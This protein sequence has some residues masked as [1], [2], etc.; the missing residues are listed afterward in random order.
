MK[1]LFVSITLLGA[2][3]FSVSILGTAQSQT[4]FSGTWALDMKKTRDLP[5]D[6]KSYTLTV[7]QT[8][9][10]ISYESK[11]EGDLNAHHKQDQAGTGTETPIAAPLP[12]PNSSGA[13]G[14]GN[15]AVS[16]HSAQG[17]GSGKVMARGRAIGM[18]I[19]R[20]NCTL[21]GKEAAREVGGISPGQI[22]RRAQWRRGDK[23]LEF[24][25]AR[26][27]DVQGKTVTSTVKE[28]WELS[29]DGKVL[30]V[31]RTVN[32]LA[33]WDEATLIFTRQ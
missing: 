9:Q 32:L 26:D 12:Q 18:V 22:R 10:Q 19:R 7:K 8:E 1:K 28:Q 2:L 27:F 20:M 15:P 29:D 21:D 3:M 13:A 14:I 23:S 6:L 16:D 5:P 4:N 33:G 17:S 31:R 11:V 25:I 24:N 30:K